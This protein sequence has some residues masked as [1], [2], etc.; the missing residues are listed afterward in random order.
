MHHDRMQANL[1]QQHDITR[2]GAGQRRIAHRMTAIFY[3]DG[4]AGIL[5]HVRQCLRQDI[6]FRKP[7]FALD[8]TAVV[9][10]PVPVLLQSRIL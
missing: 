9:H 8:F 10:F 6:S 4:L 7:F 2:K 1:L 3:D 5:P